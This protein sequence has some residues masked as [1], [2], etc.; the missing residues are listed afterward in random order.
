MASH[1]W[2]QHKQVSTSIVIRNDSGTPVHNPHGVAEVQSLQNLEYVVPDISITKV[3]VQYLSDKVRRIT[4]WD[5]DVAGV[6]GVH[7]QYA[8]G[9]QA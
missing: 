5:I 1:H 8:V 9:I 2:L 3:G 7:D 6:V 4:N